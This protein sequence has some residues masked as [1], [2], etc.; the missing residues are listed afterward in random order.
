MPKDTYEEDSAK[1]QG[2]RPGPEDTARG[3]KL[4]DESYGTRMAKKQ[5]GALE[6]EI[7]TADPVLAKSVQGSRLGLTRVAAELKNIDQVKEFNSLRGGYFSTAAEELFLIKLVKNQDLTPEQRVKEC[8]VV[9]ALFDSPHSAHEAARKERGYIR[10]LDDGPTERLKDVEYMYNGKKKIAAEL[11]EM[12]P[13][14]EPV[15]RDAFAEA[16]YRKWADNG[17]DKGDGLA[18]LLGGADG[19]T[20]KKV[21]QDCVKKSIDGF[22][23]FLKSEFPN[24]EA[25]RPT[26]SEYVSSLEKE[27]ADMM[28][29]V[30]DEV[31]KVQNETILAKLDLV[32]KAEESPAGE[33]SAATER[34]SAE[35]SVDSEQKAPEIEPKETKSRSER[36]KEIESPTKPKGGGGGFG[37]GCAAAMLVGFGIDMLGKLI[38]HPQSGSDPIIGSN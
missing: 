27:A 19:K 4:H 21:I 34:K 29:R 38:T 3:D 20:T 7:K 10:G 32:G 35:T 37:R 31:V 36:S 15:V 25:K 13:D 1:K 24:E 17:F 8:E 23:D 12:M 11:K 16:A 26:E 5:P 28:E 6:A 9:K 30:L 2:D 18:E 22:E 14:L 33:N